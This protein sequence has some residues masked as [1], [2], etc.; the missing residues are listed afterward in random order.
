MNSTFAL[1]GGMN[2]YLI[3]VK[4][5]GKEFLQGGF[6]EGA[7]RVRALQQINLQV[8]AGKTLGLVGESGCGK[9]TLAKIIMRLEYPTQ[10]SVFFEGQDI[11]QLRGKEIAKY[12]R[13]LGMIFQDPLSSINPRHT[14][15][16]T[17]AEP[18]LIHSAHCR[19]ERTTRVLNLLAAVGLPADI[20]DSYPHELSGGQRQRVG[21]AR[22]IA[23]QP[24]LLVADEPV[25]S[26]DVSVR[27]QILNLLKD[28]QEKFSLS[29]LFISHDLAV[30]R[31]MSDTI[32]VMYAGTIVEQANSEDLFRAPRHPYTRLL[33]DS[34]P[35][36]GQMSSCIPLKARVAREGQGACPFYGSCPSV[37]DLC[38]VAAPS[39]RQVADGHFLACHRYDTR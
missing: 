33:L 7:M 37:L 8:E 3:E 11:F 6:W 28:I 2:N 22:A 15:E 36:M 5:L 38:A 16:E 14:V 39:L 31:F 19:K 26:L 13:Q 17:L 25:S 20:M 1:V 9:S 24:K 21:I 10:G 23:M 32:A 4:N 27:A 29:S 18:F 35:Q 34:L 30:V 12:R